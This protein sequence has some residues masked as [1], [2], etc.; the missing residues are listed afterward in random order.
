MM[1][2]REKKMMMGRRKEKKKGMNTMLVDDE[3]EEGKE[4]TLREW[5]GFCSRIR[6]NDHARGHQTN[7]CKYEHETT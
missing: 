4:G 5:T 6:G 1:M 7:I 3:A 2:I